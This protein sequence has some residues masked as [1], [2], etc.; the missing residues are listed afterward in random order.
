L[1][2]VQNTSAGPSVPRR[3]ENSREVWARRRP[4]RAS[5]RFRHDLVISPLL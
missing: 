3:N 1:P 2:G 5:H 4:T